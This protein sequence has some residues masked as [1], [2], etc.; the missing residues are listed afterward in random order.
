MSCLRVWIHLVWSTKNRENLI[1]TNIEEKVYNHIKENAIINDIYIDCIGGGMDHVHC[2]IQLR[3]EQTIANVVNKI[4]GESSFWINKSQIMVPHF[5]WQTD[6]YATS[7]SLSNVR[8][9]RKYIENQKIHHKP[10]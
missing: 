3:A 1:L 5:A 4:K 8:R 9:V 2:L 7:V 10:K 6:Y